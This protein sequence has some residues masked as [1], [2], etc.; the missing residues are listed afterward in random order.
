MKNEKV[1]Q[2][3]KETKYSPFKGAL[4]ESLAIGCLIGLICMIA[5]I[6]MIKGAYHKAREKLSKAIHPLPENAKRITKNYFYGEEV[7]SIGNERYLITK[8]L[9]RD[10]STKRKIVG[11]LVKEGKIYVTYLGG[12]DE[13]PFSRC[14][15]G[16]L[17]KY[18]DYIPLS[19]EERNSEK[20]R[21]LELS[22]GEQNENRKA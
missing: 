12:S 1:D 3:E 16:Y 15:E 8:S 11:R 19:E 17:S 21:K 6:H 13:L 2:E 18:Y 10:L 4:E 9:G 5:P 7:H 20:I 14:T 22:M